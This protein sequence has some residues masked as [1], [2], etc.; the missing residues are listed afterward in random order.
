MFVFGFQ[1]GEQAPHLVLRAERT[2]KL[3]YGKNKGSCAGRRLRLFR[4]AQMRVKR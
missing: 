2:R 1:R 4:A 3:S